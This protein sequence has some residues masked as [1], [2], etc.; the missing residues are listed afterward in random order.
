MRGDESLLR[1]ATLEGGAPSPPG[2]GMKRSRDSLLF[3]FDPRA[4]PRRRRSGA[5]QRKRFRAQNWND[6]GSQRRTH[7]VAEVVAIEVLSHGFAATF[8]AGL[9]APD[10]I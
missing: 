3:W 1:G 5:L 2:A 9:E 4:P 6:L 8:E 10:G 7:Q